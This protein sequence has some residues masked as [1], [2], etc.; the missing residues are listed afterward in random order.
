MMMPSVTFKSVW[1][2]LVPLYLPAFQVWWPGFLWIFS[3]SQVILKGW[4]YHYPLNYSGLN[5]CLFILM[6]K[7]SDYS[8]CWKGVITGCQS[9][10]LLFKLFWTENVPFS[11]PAV[12]I[13]W[14]T[15]CWG[16]II[17]F[18]QNLCEFTM[19]TPA[20]TFKLIWP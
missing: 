19:M 4:H 20:A 12:Q 15:F 11:L 1:P 2:E 14:Q 17:K 18:S 10:V 6:S 8:F 13:W 7:L 3:Q 5:W 9:H 16:G